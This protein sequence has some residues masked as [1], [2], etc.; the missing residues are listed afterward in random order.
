MC[1]CG[2]FPEWGLRESGDK[3]GLGLISFQWEIGPIMAE[4]PHIIFLTHVPWREGSH[5]REGQ[6][7]PPGTAS[8]A[9]FTFTAKKVNQ[10]NTKFLG[11]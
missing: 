11:N 9:T 1:H 5:Y 10:S 6:V 8:L 4:S 3:L 2:L 7:V